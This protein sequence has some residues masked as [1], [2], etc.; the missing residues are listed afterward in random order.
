MVTVK[1]KIELTIKG[2]ES[3]SRVADLLLDSGYIIKKG[4]DAKITIYEESEIVGS[5]GDGGIGTG[6][7]GGYLG[8]GGAG[9]NHDTNGA[10]GGG[11]CLTKEGMPITP[12]IKNTP[13]EKYEVCCSEEE[14]TCIR[15]K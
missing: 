12:I 1:K 13:A 9:G 15:Q 7:G 6:I 8:S 10:G 3:A 4:H 2:Y 11:V 5:G 14:Y